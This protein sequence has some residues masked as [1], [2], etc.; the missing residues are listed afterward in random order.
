MFAAIYSWAYQL[1]PITCF[2][3][4]MLM[5]ALQ[6]GEETTGHAGDAEDDPDVEGGECP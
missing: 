5:F 6:S 1:L 2:K 4:R 3:F